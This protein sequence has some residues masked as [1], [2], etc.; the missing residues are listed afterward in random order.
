MNISANPRAVTGHARV[1]HPTLQVIRRASFKAAP[2]KNGGGITH[3]AM[4]VPASGETFRW[5]VSVAHIDASGPFSVFAQYNRKMVLLQGAGLDLRFGG[6]ITKA[7]R[8]VGEWVEFDGAV[9]AHCELLNGRCVDLNLMVA[10]GD[11]A[12]ARVERCIEPVALNAPF[13]ETLLI[14][15][16][17]CSISLEIQGEPAVT[18]EPWDL[19]VVS[20][21]AG[22]LHRLE[23]AAAAHCS[24]AAVF[25]AALKLVGGEQQAGFG[26]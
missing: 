6:G 22:R 21:G 9:A 5:R 14:F 15:P 18:L 26:V 11:A 17:D 23:S 25:L 1:P 19:A 10:K 3:E 13:G 8:T 4:R 7:L 12:A 2:W 16:I 20:D 24:A